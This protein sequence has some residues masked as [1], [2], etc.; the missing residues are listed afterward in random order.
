MTS[1][2]LSIMFGTRIDSAQDPLVIK[3]MEIGMEFMDLTGEAHV[4]PI[5]ITRVLTALTTGV[6][7]NAVD[8]IK[9]LQW[10]PTRTRTRARWV[11]DALVDVYGSMIVR[12]K[13]QM[14]ANENVE[15]CLA[16]TLLLK[17]E[18]KKLDWEDVCML[19][20][21]FTLGGV[22]SVSFLAQRT[23]YLL[24]ILTRSHRRLRVSFSGLLHSL[25]HIRMCKDVHTKNLTRSL[26]GRL[27]RLRK[28]RNSSRTLGQS[29]R[30]FSESALHS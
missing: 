26:E 25:R 1:N 29:S 23:A 14:D 11:H 9:P 21:V 28:M 13:A 3:A 22:H 16:K 2:M 12:V 7:S 24:S 5:H 4:Y 8:F 18:E 10:F 15:D 6:L 27:G 17:Y 19:T 20:S 30:K